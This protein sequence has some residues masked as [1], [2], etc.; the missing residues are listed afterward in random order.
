MY[1]GEGVGERASTTHMNCV[2]LQPQL[3]PMEAQLQGSLAASQGCMGK[4]VGAVVGLSV[5]LALGLA[6]GVV[7]VGLAVGETLGEDVGALEGA[8][9]EG[10]RVGE[11]VG[12]L[13]EGLRVGATVGLR[14]GLAV[15]TRSLERNPQSLPSHSR[16]PCV[17]RQSI[18]SVSRT[19]TSAPGTWCTWNSCDAPP[20]VHASA[21]NL[22]PVMVRHRSSMRRR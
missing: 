17:V 2:R 10:L 1:D 19:C 15:G 18:P 12:V 13:V 3:L 22:V 5:G 14:V 9:V 6:V 11:T 16:M 20:H 21:V 4:G 8:A 7:V